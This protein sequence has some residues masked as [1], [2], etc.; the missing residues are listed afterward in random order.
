MMDDTTH[1]RRK[2]A[3]GATIRW[4]LWIWA[5]GCGVL[6]PSARA[7][8]PLAVVDFSRQPDASPGPAM[9]A[10]LDAQKGRIET[11]FGGPAY[12]FLQQGSLHL[13]ARP[14]PAAS[15]ILLWRL[16]KR[17]DK[18]ILRLT[19]NGFRVSPRSYRRVEV[20]MAPV[21]LPGK[22]ADVTDSDRNDACFYLLVAFDGP[23]HLYQGQRVPDTIAYVW[24][25]GAWKTGADV[26]RERK[27]GEFMRHIAL[28]RGP[29]R[30]GELRTLVRDVEADF[31]LAYPERA[32]KGIPDVIEVGLMIDSNTV[33]SEA[34]SML[35]SVR[36]LP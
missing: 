24:A 6:L 29:D 22:G 8:E 4:A 3:A 2:P 35:R 36:F 19:P 21:R 5:A 30:L 25:D 18:V 31:R 33:K 14:G 23:R 27:Y 12:F 17:E 20:T 1:R 26:G 13:V 34:E 7:S 10:W 11:K 15:S 9:A 32:E 28:G 16:L